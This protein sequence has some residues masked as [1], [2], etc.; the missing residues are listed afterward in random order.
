[1]PQIDFGAVSGEGYQTTIERQVYFASKFKNIPNVFVTLRQLDEN[2]VPLRNT[3]N[4]SV[5]GVLNR[6]FKSYFY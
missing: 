2:L 6:N 4:Q 5:I 1:M 3:Q